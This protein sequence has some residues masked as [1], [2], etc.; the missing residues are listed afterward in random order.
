MHRIDPVLCQ[1]PSK[2]IHVKKKQQQNNNSKCSNAKTNKILKK[3]KKK[4][5]NR[6]QYNNNNNDRDSVSDE[7]LDSDSNYTSSSKTSDDSDDS[8]DSDTL[9]VSPSPDPSATKR[10]DTIEN[11]DDNK[12]NNS[13][14]SCPDYNILTDDMIDKYDL[15]NFKTSSEFEEYCNFI[16]ELPRNSFC[17]LH[18]STDR[19]VYNCAVGFFQYLMMLDQRNIHY[20]DLMGICRPKYMRIPGPDQYGDIIEYCKKKQYTYISNDGIV[21]QN[22]IP[23]Y[24]WLGIRYVGEII[25]PKER[26]ESHARKTL[27]YI[28]IPADW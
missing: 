27:E 6:K 13:F 11:S 14:I 5:K 15:K 26:V 17:Y 23:K 20:N 2:Q 28:P 7:M 3:K 16:Q 10:R 21:K 18:R 25:D 1:Q 22:R 8:D 12:D 9:S 24:F 4:K 19:F